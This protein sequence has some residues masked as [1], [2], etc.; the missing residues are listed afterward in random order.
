MN[1]LELSQKSNMPNLSHDQIAVKILYIL[2]I[3]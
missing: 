2:M 3:T 1:Y